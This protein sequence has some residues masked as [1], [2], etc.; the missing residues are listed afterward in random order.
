MKPF[1]MEDQVGHYIRAIGHKLRYIPD[2]K[3]S[4]HNLTNQ[5]GKLLGMIASYNRAGKEVN[6]KCLEEAMELRGPSVTSLLD[7]L[8]KKG[9]IQRVS[10]KQDGRSSCIIATEKGKKLV[11]EIH[12]AFVTSD[13]VLKKGLSEEEEQ[14]CL[15]LL[16]RAYENSS[17]Q[18]NA[19]E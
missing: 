6:R 10:S 5:Q 18:E 12:D 9:Y 2:K 7:G 14:L 17:N 3:L 11:A 1:N 15:Q 19:G 8:G 13:N 4:P 16:K